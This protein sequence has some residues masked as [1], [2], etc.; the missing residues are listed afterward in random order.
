[1]ATKTISLTRQAQQRAHAGAMPG[2]RV[3]VTASAA[4]GLANEV[5]LHQRLPVDPQAPS[6]PQ[7][8]ELAGVCTPADL[9]ELPVNNPSPGASP[10][11]F[12]RSSLDVVLRSQK[13]ADD[14]WSRLK[15][16]VTALLVALDKMDTLGAAETANLTSAGS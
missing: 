2:W 6:G 14:L 8:D 3:V 11:L 15:K 10:S 16:D 1:M 9:A 7:A 4:A 13:E 5:F 12:R